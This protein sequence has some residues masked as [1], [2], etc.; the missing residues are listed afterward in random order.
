LEWE[1][2]RG[3]EEESEEESNAEDSLGISVG[4][5]RKKSCSGKGD[6]V[7]GKARGWR[8]RWLFVGARIFFMEAVG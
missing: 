7:W 4:K 2:R 3:G 6:G 5:E 1:A 8:L